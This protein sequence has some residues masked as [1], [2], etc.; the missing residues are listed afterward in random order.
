MIDHPRRLLK[1]QGGGNGEL[2]DCHVIPA[3]RVLYSARL[4]SRAIDGL[5]RSGPRAQRRDKVRKAFPQAKE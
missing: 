2:V 3:D 1:N 4:H 5:E